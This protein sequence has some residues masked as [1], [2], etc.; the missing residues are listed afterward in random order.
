MIGLADD[1]ENTQ[2]HRGEPR[3]LGKIAS[4]KL[5]R[6]QDTP[7]GDK[8][9]IGPVHIGQRVRFLDVTTAFADGNAG[10]DTLLSGVL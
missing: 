1:L 7:Q 10:R 9:V 4:V 6:A 3:L 8:A 2:L 5:C